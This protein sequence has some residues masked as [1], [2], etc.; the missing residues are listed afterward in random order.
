MPRLTKSWPT[1]A[2]PHKLLDCGLLIAKSPEEGSAISKENRAEIQWL[3]TDVVMPAMNGRQLAEQILKISPDTKILYLSGY[4]NNAIAHY[5]VLEEGIWCLPKP[6]GLSA[7]VSKVR[8]V[9]DSCV[10]S[11]GG[12]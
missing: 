10:E 3:I 4:A 8:E 6:F 9:L 5:G 12:E 11:E 1:R 7:R 2:T